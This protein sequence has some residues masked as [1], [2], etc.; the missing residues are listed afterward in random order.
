MS[1]A[2]R[3]KSAAERRPASHSPASGGARSEKLKG[4]VTEIWGDATSVVLVPLTADGKHYPAGTRLEICG[5]TVTVQE[6]GTVLARK[7]AEIYL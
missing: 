3:D 7:Y 1:T 2:S 6:D 5:E 4:P